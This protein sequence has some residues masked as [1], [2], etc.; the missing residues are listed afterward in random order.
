MTT[1]VTVRT[2]G[3]PVRVTQIDDFSH[4]VAVGE[5]D[6]EQHTV[7]QMTFEVPPNSEHTFYITSTRSIAFEELPLPVAGI[8]EETIV[9]V[10]RQDMGE[11]LPP[12]TDEQEQ[13]KVDAL[14]DDDPDEYPAPVLADDSGEEID[15]ALRA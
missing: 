8:A 13:S 11:T 5:M 12:Y 2:H 3:W 6:G 10:A 15:P 9:D 1:N 4:K 7:T 14:S